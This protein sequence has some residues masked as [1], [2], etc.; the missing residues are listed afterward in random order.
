MAKRKGIESA[1]QHARTAL[2]QVMK[3]NFKGGLDE[4][5]NAARDAMTELR[6]R[7]KPRPKDFNEAV[8]NFQR[9]GQSI[10]AENAKQRQAKPAAPAPRKPRDRRAAARQAALTRKAKGNG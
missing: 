5:R 9:V 7:E 2:G 1:G 10:A 3:G 6:A 8:S 4:A